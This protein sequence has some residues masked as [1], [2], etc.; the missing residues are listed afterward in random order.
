VKTK[1]TA[2]NSNPKPEEHRDKMIDSEDS[3][4]YPE[5]YEEALA[6]CTVLAARLLKLALQREE[7][8]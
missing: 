7:A 1:S 3:E 6:Q 2:K 8:S 5:G 4:K